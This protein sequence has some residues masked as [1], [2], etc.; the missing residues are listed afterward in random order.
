MSRDGRSVERPSRDMALSARTNA[1]ALLA[2]VPK[3]LLPAGV[4]IV[5]AQARPWRR[6]GPRGCGRRADEADRCAGRDG[7]A[8]S[9]AVAGPGPIAVAIAAAVARPIDIAVDVTVD[10]AIDVSVHIAV[11]SRI[12]SRS[13]MHPG[14]SPA[15]PM[16]AA[17]VHAAA[18]V[19]PAPAVVAH[20]ASA[21][22]AAAPHLR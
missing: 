17:G 13:A 2:S 5:P 4:G 8:G 21:T 15:R 11:G 1:K 7:A 20:S 6:S 16:H 22:A 14:T 12:P 9:P 18:P 10:I 3:P 19:H